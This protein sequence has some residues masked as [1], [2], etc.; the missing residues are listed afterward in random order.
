MLRDHFSK[1]EELSSQTLCE[2]GAINK[3]LRESLAIQDQK[4]DAHHK[5][6][7]AIVSAQSKN[8]DKLNEALRATNETQNSMMINFTALVTGVLGELSK[9][10]SANQPIEELAKSMSVNKM[11]DVSLVHILSQFGP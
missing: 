7:E 6:Q 4:L 3:A 9:L 11:G 2:L 10:T 1:A 8:I 5:K